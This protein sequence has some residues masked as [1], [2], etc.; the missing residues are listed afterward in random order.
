[1]NIIIVK[2]TIFGHHSQTYGIDV[3]VAWFLIEY[4]ELGH[5]IIWE[6]RAEFG[7]LCYFYNL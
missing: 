5:I 4:G 6:V 7:H 2:L 3:Y 1:M